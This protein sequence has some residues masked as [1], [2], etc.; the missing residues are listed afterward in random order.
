VSRRSSATSSNDAKATSGAIAGAARESNSFDS[1]TTMAA[2]TDEAPAEHSDSSRKRDVDV[3]DLGTEADDPRAS[4]RRTPNRV[5]PWPRL[6]E[7]VVIDIARRLDNENHISVEFVATL[8]LGPD[9]RLVLCKI[10]SA[11]FHVFAAL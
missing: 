2:H 6:R 5:K 8:D 7:V 10:R 3:G 9:S 4:D 11:R 1:R